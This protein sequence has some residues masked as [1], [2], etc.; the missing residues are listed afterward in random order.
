MNYEIVKGLTRYLLEQLGEDPLRP[1]LVD[2]PGRVARAWEEWTSGYAVDV[3]ALFTTFEDGAKDVD[4][5]IL[6]RDIPFYSHCEHHLAPFFG[7]VTVAYIPSDRIVGLSKINRLVQ[8]FANRLQVQERLTTQIADALV[9]NL[10]PVGCA[11]VVTARHLCMESRGIKQQG[12]S[13]RTSAL[14]GVFKDDP[15]T[16][17]EF[18]LLLAAG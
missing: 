10:N 7:Q 14:H 17:Q 6:V 5:M 11:V 2:T 18:L 15:S 8:V 4:E 9:A 13:T 3:P 12:H 1:G 16:R